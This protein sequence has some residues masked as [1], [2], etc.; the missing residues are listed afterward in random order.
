MKHC[1]FFNFFLPIS[2]TMLLI[3]HLQSNLKN[4]TYWCMY[5][6]NFKSLIHDLY[7]SFYKHWSHCF[8][9]IDLHLILNYEALFKSVS[10]WAL[11]FNNDDW[12]VSVMMLYRHMRWISGMGIVRA[13]ALCNSPTHRYANGCLR[14]FIH[15]K[16]MSI[17]GWI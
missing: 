14:Q 3:F 13:R 12:D 6:L 16:P 8:P 1:Y 7:H 17:Y 10:I 11:T 5:N 2:P 4:V 15:W 9:A